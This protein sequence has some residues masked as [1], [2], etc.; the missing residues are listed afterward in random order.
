MAM[1][2]DCQTSGAIFHTEIA[3]LKVSISVDLPFN[4]E[5]NEKEASLLEANL[6]NVVELVLK[7]YFKK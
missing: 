2:T 4:I 7:P 3:S 5:L 6:H 1:A